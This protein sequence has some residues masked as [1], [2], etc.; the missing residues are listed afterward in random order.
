MELESRERLNTWRARIEAIV[1]AEKRIAEAAKDIAEHW[2]KRQA[3][4]VGKDLIVCMSRRNCVDLYDQVVKFRP[5]WHSADEAAGKIKIV[6]TGS[7]CTR[8]LGRRE[9]LGIS[10]AHLAHWSTI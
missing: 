7:W 2:E 9:H 4:E 3:A 10:K 6:L 1:G 8:P 5:D